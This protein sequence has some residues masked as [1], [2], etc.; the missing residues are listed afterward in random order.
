MAETP[1][2]QDGG[3]G[4][5]ANLASPDEVGTLRRAPPDTS[6]TIVRQYIK[7]LSFENP[8]APGIYGHMS[9][10]PAIRIS[11]DINPALLAERRHEVA[12]GLQVRAVK[13][14]KVAFV[15]ELQY[16]GVVVVGDSL[17]EDETDRL[18]EIET[19]RHLFPFIRAVVAGMTRDGGFPPLLLNPIDFA[20]VYQMRRRR[21]AEQTAAAAEA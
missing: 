13:A 6:F 16:A 12:V 18:L 2:D 21:D 17:S 9:E 20:Q 19:P 8:N 7:D 3:S 10:G 11:V 5:G 1:P 4:G 14:D 15:L